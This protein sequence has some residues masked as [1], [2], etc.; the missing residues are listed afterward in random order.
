MDRPVD[1][2]GE[3]LAGVY[4]VSRPVAIGRLEQQRVYVRSGSRRKEQRVGRPAQVAAAEHRPFTARRRHSDP[5]PGR[6]QDVPGASEGEVDV[7]RQRHRLTDRRRS[8][9][10]AHLLDVG[11][12]VE[13]Q[14]RPVLAPAIGVGVQRLLFEQ[15][16][17]VGEDDLGQPRRRFGGIDR[18]GPSVPGQHREV[19]GVVQVGVGQDDRVEVVEVEWHRSPVAAAQ[20]RQS[21]EHPAVD[22]QLARPVSTRNLLP[23]TVPTPPRKVS[24]A[25][26]T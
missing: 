8:E 13:R 1:H 24:A 25:V 21:L 9:H 6:A 26:M 2:L 15:V 18:A 3:S 11:L 5:R 20:T 10:S 23:V 12:G 7:A 19:P 22:Q 17:A 16:G 4:F 14:G